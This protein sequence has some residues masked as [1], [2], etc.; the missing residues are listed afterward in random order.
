L[1]WEW[2]ELRKVTQEAIRAAIHQ[3]IR[4][5]DIH[6]LEDNWGMAGQTP[7]LCLLPPELR[8]G[9]RTRLHLV[10]AL[11][12]PQAEALEVAGM[13]ASGVTVRQAKIRSRSS[14]PLLAIHAESTHRR[15]PA[16]IG[17]H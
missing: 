17:P 5:V 14:R 7:A 4:L 11:D 9:I 10:K 1:A 3:H 13:E 16:R 2:A 8:L 12:L 15:L 6:R